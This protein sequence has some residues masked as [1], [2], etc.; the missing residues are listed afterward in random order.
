MAGWRGYSSEKKMA[1]KYC[2]DNGLD[3]IE[4]KADYQT[5]KIKG[6]G[7]CI[8]I[9]PHKTSAGN[10]HLRLRDENSKNKERAFQIM[11]DFDKLEMGCTFSHK[12]AW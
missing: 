10:Y 7:V 9:Y 8:V 6:E 11:K 4:S 2:K 3:L 5:A 12:G 1:Q